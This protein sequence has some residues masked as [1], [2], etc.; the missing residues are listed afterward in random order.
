MNVDADGHMAWAVPFYFI[1]GI[2]QVAMVAT[3]V[4]AGVYVGWKYKKQ[5]RNGA[6]R[7]WKKVKGWGRS[8]RKFARNS[9]R[10]K[11]KQEANPS[12]EHTKGKRKSTNDKHTKPRPGRASEKKKQSPNWRSRK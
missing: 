4:G 3:A 2:G 7:A 1:P 10:H 8:I 9:G 6:S 12:A 5:I 11:K